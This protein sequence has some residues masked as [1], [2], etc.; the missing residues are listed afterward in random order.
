M[1]TLCCPFRPAF[2][3]TSWLL[4]AG[5]RE[6]LASSVTAWICSNSPGNALDVPEAGNR[7]A[8]KRGLRIHANERII[9]S[10]DPYER[11]RQADRAIQ[12]IATVRRLRWLSRP[13]R[14]KRPGCQTA[15]GM[16]RS[17]VSPIAKL[18]GTVA[19]VLFTTSVLDRL[20]NISLANAGSISRLQEFSVP[21]RQANRAQPMRTHRR[22]ELPR[23]PLGAQ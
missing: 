21:R 19:P 3:A 15:S 14:T 16:R 9:A 23:H 22:G 5:T 1:R 4:G 18:G 11:F 20:Q 6:K 10:S 7:A 13:V 17:N 2:R 8:V 12:T